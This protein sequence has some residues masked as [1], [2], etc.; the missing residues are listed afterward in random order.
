VLRAECRVE[1]AGDWTNGILV[2]IEIDQSV[3]G[4]PKESRGL[5]VVIGAAE[6]KVGAFSSRVWA[7]FRTQMEIE[8]ARTPLVVQGLSKLNA[9][10]T[11][12]VPRGGYR[13][14][15]ID[16]SKRLGVRSYSILRSLFDMCPGGGCTAQ[17]LA[18]TIR[19][20][21][22]FCVPYRYGGSGQRNGLLGQR[23]RFSLSK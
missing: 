4:C 11:G 12:T 5:D 6:L 14:T 22:N 13:T 20:K 3:G 18:S 8:F 17:V 23:G 10:D 1:T 21:A 2:T 7:K 9:L 16:V 19:T 15:T